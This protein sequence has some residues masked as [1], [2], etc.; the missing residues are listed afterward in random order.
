MPLPK[1]EQKKTYTVNLPSG[2]KV[3]FRPWIVREE[4][5]YMYATEGLEDKDEMTDH[6]EE[7]LAKCMLDDTKIADLSE[8]DFLAFAVE[9]RKRSKGENHD[10][11]FTCPHCEAIN[12][13]VSLS[14]IDDIVSEGMKKDPL[15]I[16]E[17]EFTFKDLSRSKL[18]K[19]REIQSESKKKLYYLIYCLAG[20]ATPE[21]TYNKFSEKETIEF[22]ETMDPIDFKQ[23]TKDFAGRLPIF[24]VKRILKCERCE[25][26]TLVYV[27]K[28][29]D[30][31]V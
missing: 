14:L 5:E 25:K 3:K 13:A 1:H 18:K 19:I 12:D 7:L 9:L 21:Q 31:F 11:I 2:R 29:T 6:I 20:V 24:A 10:I 23:L 16:G 27:D 22:F 17:Y 26:D 15:E 8:V 28:V 4:Q 30:F